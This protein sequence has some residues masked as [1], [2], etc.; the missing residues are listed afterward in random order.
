MWRRSL[1]S[2]LKR[3]R[4]S[5]GN[6]RF[7]KGARTCGP[8][9]GGGTLG[10]AALKTRLDDGGDSP[11]VGRKR[12]WSRRGGGNMRRLTKARLVVSLAFIA[13]SIG[14]ARGQ[15]SVSETRRKVAE[16]EAKVAGLLPGTFDFGLHNEL[17]HLYGGLDERKSM[18]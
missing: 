2:R 18:I 9:P 11:T 1:W 8:V 15:D 17:R 14:P 6:S 13:A 16:L 7:H 12:R 10:T 5:P 3:R 4:G